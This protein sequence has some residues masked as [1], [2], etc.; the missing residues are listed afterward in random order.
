MAIHDFITSTLNLTS[1]SIQEIDAKRKEDHLFV[2]ITL[3]NQHPTCP[4]CGGP[5][6]S[7]G[8]I[9]RTYNH[10][11]LGDTPSSI[12]WKRRRY[13]CKDCFKTFSEDNPFGPEYFHQT[14][15]VLYKIAADFQNLHLS[16]KDIDERYNTSVTTVQLYA[17]SFIQVPRL[18]LPI[19]LGIDELHSNMAKYGGSY[20]CSF[21]DNDA[22]VLN[23][24][25]PDRSKRTLSTH[26]E[27]IPLEERKRVLYVTID[28][29]EPYKQVSLKYFPNCKISV[30]P[31]HVV[32]HLSDGFTKLRVSLMN[33]VPKESPAY[34]LLKHF[35]RLLESDCFLDNEPK[36]N[37]F[38]RQKMNYRNLYDA[39]LNL[40]PLL[41]QAYEL[42]ED[43]RYF[44]RN[45]TYPECIEELT[46]LIR[47]FKESRLVCYSE[48]INLLENW[49][50]EI[51]NSFQ[52]PTADRKQSNAL[53]ESLN[54]KM[55]EF[56][57]I[58]NGLSNFE[59]FRA[60]VIYALNYRI[61]FSLTSNI[62]AYNRKQKK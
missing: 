7:K 20:L 28:M 15:A 60:R 19:N 37:H 57:M 34:Y 41:K 26:L 8:Y 5:V 4:Y 42:K 44:N 39:L 10:L 48:F 21:V 11:P 52:R 47:Y 6:V 9:H 32:K 54:Q 22:R 58:S 18:T 55:R 56:I 51:C 45:S 25:L 12:H 27:K 30:D 13:T 50:E 43:Y 1:D 35:H 2:Y 62:Q 61:G 38:F 53:A 59:R 49:F 40:N 23:E 29:W 24:L 46:D 36:Y 16:Y 14:Y 31:F 3:V 33:Q 17:D